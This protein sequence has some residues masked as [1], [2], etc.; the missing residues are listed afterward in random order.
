MSEAA[1]SIMAQSWS[2]GSQIA[3]KKRNNIPGESFLRGNFLGWN[4]PGGNFLGGSFSGGN[5]PRTEFIKFILK[6]FNTY[7]PLMNFCCKTETLMLQ[8]NANLTV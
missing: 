1:P 5:L 2:W 6:F 3:V 4:A 8:I 7:A